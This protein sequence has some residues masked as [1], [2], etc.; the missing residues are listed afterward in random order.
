MKL[1]ARERKSLIA[2]GVAA[3]V[4][5]LLEFVALP[6]WDSVQTSSGSLFLANKELRYDRELLAAKQLRDQAVT[7]QARLSEEEHRLIVAPDTDQAGAQLQ[8]W[9]ADR[10]AGQQMRLV[11]SE[12]LAP[13]AIG[14]NFVRIPVR[15]E[16]TGRMTQ[17]TQ[18]FNTITAGERIVEVDELQISGS[19]DKEKR[20]HCEVVIGAVMAK[21][22]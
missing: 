7:L 5:V 15:L 18:F 6:H 19:G 16:L 10:A 12:F 8:K 13:S 22:K 11:R 17:L 20:V 3:L 4:F 21:A 2:V 9:L 1:Q 14:E